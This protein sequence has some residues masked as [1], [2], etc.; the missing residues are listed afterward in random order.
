MT[1]SQYFG[2]RISGGA[3]G[4]FHT[5]ENY[6]ENVLSQEKALL[7]RNI[8]ADLQ[9]ILGFS[10]NVSGE[11][12]ER[13]VSLLKAKI[14][15]P[16]TQS[17]TNDGKVQSHICRTMAE[18]LNHRYGRHVI[19]PNAAP[20]IVC[21]QVSE[22]MS[23]LF[24]GVKSEFL[25]VSTDV[26]RTLDNLGIL[27]RTLESMFDRLYG[28]VQAGTDDRVKLESYNIEHVYRDVL[29]EID[30]QMALLSNMMNLTMNES[31][32]TIADLT[33][34]DKDFYGLI[35]S[36]KNDVGGLDLS[37]KMTYVLNNI[38]NVAVAAQTI[39]RALRAIG[40]T[41]AE[42]KSSHSVPQLLEK[43]HEAF[44]RKNPHPSS[45]D[46][47]K[48][49]AVLQI[50]RSNDYSWD[51][52]TAHINSRAERVKA[53]PR[54]AVK[55]ANRAGHKR[56][57]KKRARGGAE[58]DN[59]LEKRL[60]RQTKA[61][62]VLFRDFEQRLEQQYK[63]I[64]GA[65][66]ILAK[67]LGAQVPL[68]DHLHRFVR[69]MES[70]SSSGVTRENFYLALTGYQ[71]D[72]TSKEER[73]RFLG[74][75]TAVSHALK[76]L[77]GGP[78]GEHF[79]T[80]MSAVDAVIETI[81][82]FKDTYLEPLTSISVRTA[83]GD[84]DMIDDD[85]DEQIAYGGADS[86]SDSNSSDS[87]DLPLSTAIPDAPVSPVASPMAAP[88]APVD[89]ITTPSAPT[90]T[91]GAGD[92]TYVTLDQAIRH[93]MFFFNVAKVK[94]NLSIASKDIKGY[95][96]DYETVLGDAMGDQIINIKKQYES[97]KKTYDGDATDDAKLLTAWIADTPAGSI[98]GIAAP[99][100]TQFRAWRQSIKDNALKFQKEQ[101]NVKIDLIKTVEAI[102]IYLSKF[103]DAIASNPN[104]VKELNQLLKS[105]D[106]IAKW[107]TDRSGNNLV[108]LFESTPSALSG[109]EEVRVDNI[110]QD[111]Q[112]HYYNWVSN[113][114]HN[115]DATKVRLPAN[116]FLGTLPG[117]ADADEEDSVFDEI[118]ERAKKVAMTVRVLDNI[119]ST[120]AK[121]GSQYGQT[122]LNDQ[123]FMPP[124]VMLK[125]LRR[126]MYH[127]SIVMGMQTLTNNSY[128][129]DASVAS[130]V[131]QVG[132]TGAPGPE[133]ITHYKGERIVVGTD[134]FGAHSV[135]PSTLLAATA[136]KT[137]FD[138][139]AADSRE[140]AERWVRSKFCIA[141]SSIYNANG[142][143]LSG[144][145]NGW[146]ETDDLFLMT[147]KSMIAKVFTVI[148]TYDVFN[149]PLDHYSSITNT[150][151]ILG[152]DFSTPEIIPSAVELYIRLPLLAEFYREVFHFEDA[153]NDQIGDTK[154]RRITMVPEFDGVWQNFVRI[155]FEDAKYV[156]EGTYSEAQVKA[157][158]REI[159]TIYTKYKTPEDKTS[160]S[161][162]IAAFIAEINRRYGV[163]KQDEINKYVK[164]KR[165]YDATETYNAEEKLDYDLLDEKNAFG[166]RPAPSDR[167]DYAIA[168]EERKVVSP[169]DTTYI[170]LVRNFR[171]SLDS[172]IKKLLPKS[173]KNHVSFDQTIRTYKTQVEHAKDNAE[174]YRVILKAM[175]GVDHLNTVNHQKALMFHEMVVAPL[176]TLYS[177]WT[178]MDR[179][180]KKVEALD[181]AAI[182]KI[183]DAVTKDGAAVGKDAD[184][185]TYFAAL[186]AKNM[187][188]ER[189][190]HTGYVADANTG[191][192]HVPTWTAGTGADNDI[193]VY[194]GTYGA[195]S[196]LTWS[197]IPLLAKKPKDANT[198]GIR[199]FVV[200]RELIFKDLMNLVFALGSDLGELT[201]VRVQ[202][203]N[204]I[205]EYGKLVE[206]ASALLSNVKKNLELFRGV[207]DDSVIAR[208]ESNRE[209]GSIY[210]LDENLIE[211]IF[212]DSRVNSGRHQY[213]IGLSQANEKLN[214]T[215]KRLSLPWKVT[216]NLTGV[217]TT[218][219]APTG[220][221]RAESS[222]SAVDRALLEYERGLL[223]D[224]YERPMANLLYWS[225]T[226]SYDGAAFRHSLAQP[227]VQNTRVDDWPYAVIPSIDRMG[228]EDDDIK[229]L[230]TIEDTMKNMH[231]EIK[232]AL[233]AGYQPAAGPPPVNQASPFK[234]FGQAAA[235]VNWVDVTDNLGIEFDKTL[236][237]PAIPDDVKAR[238]TALGERY[239]ALFK[240]R[241]RIYQSSIR[242]PMDHRLKWY[243]DPSNVKEG[244]W[245]LNQ[246]HAGD[247]N[248]GSKNQFD[249]GLLVRLNE[250]L[251][252]YLYNGWDATSR[253]MYSG[254]INKFANG[255][256][257]AAVTKGQAI[258]DIDW[259]Q[260]G[261]LHHTGIL[262]LPAQHVS[263]FA[264]LARAMR[265]IMV[266]TRRSGDPEFRIDTMMDVPIH[267]KETMRANLPL[268]DKLFRL[269]IKKAEFLR[270]VTLHVSLV[271][272]SPYSTKYGI[273]RATA[274][275]V[276]NPVMEGL[277]V[278]RWNDITVFFDT[279]N[280]PST[281]SGIES[282]SHD[283]Y[284]PNTALLERNDVMYVPTGVVF[285]NAAPA[286]LSAVDALIAASPALQANIA[287]GAAM[288]A[289]DNTMW[290]RGTDVATAPY[291][292]GTRFNATYGHKAR[293]HRSDHAGCAY[294]SFAIYEDLGL[295]SS[296]K[297][298][299]ELA[300]EIANAASSLAKCASET[301]KELADEPKYLETH[302]GFISDYINMNKV[303]PL[304][305][306]SQLQIAIRP[307]Y[308]S[309]SANPAPNGGEYDYTTESGY[310]RP[311]FMLP[312][313]RSGETPFK[314]AYGSRLVLGRPDVKPSL[315]YMPGMSSL[316]ERYN[317][318]CSAD[319]RIEKSEYESATIAHTL[320]L[321][322]V[323]ELKF[324]R[325]VLDDK[326]G[327]RIYE[328]L[329]IGGPQAAPVG[330]A[331]YDC[332]FNIP[333]AAQPQRVEAAVTYSDKNK[334]YALQNSLDEVI[335]ITESPDQESSMNEIISS[336]HAKDKTIDSRSNARFY[337]IIDMNIVPINVHALT[338]EI[339]LIN[340]INY[341]YTYDRIVQD[342]L[343]PDM[344]VDVDNRGKLISDAYVPTS[345]KGMLTKMLLYPYA[346]VTNNEYYGLIA[347]IATGD[348]GMNLG[349][350]KFISD[351]LW[352]KLLLQELYTQPPADRQRRRPDES[353]PAGDSAQ[354]R[355]L[356]RY[357]ANP[358]A[359]MDIMQSADPA[360]FAATL[361]NAAAL[362]NA[363][364]N[365]AQ[366]SRADASQ[367][368][369]DIIAVHPQPNP[370]D[371]TLSNNTRVIAIVQALS[372][373][374]AS[375]SPPDAAPLAPARITALLTLLPEESLRAILGQYIQAATATTNNVFRA[376]IALLY[377]VMADESI[378]GV[379][380]PEATFEN[381]GQLQFAKKTDE[382]IEL[383]Q[384]EFTNIATRDSAIAVRNDLAQIGR[385]R[386]DTTLVRNLFFLCNAQRVMRMIM[387]DEVQY[388]ES[389]V[390]NASTVL[391]REITDFE[392][393][394]VFDA[395]VFQN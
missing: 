78:S 164:S 180:I 245:F 110:A 136:T 93:L 382:G 56:H 89:A 262:G 220:S 44:E 357:A 283:Y 209:P 16:K 65:V 206:Y 319:Q 12:L 224:S 324:F 22:L 177:V 274:Q 7:I 119:V 73:Q 126:Y 388:L 145:N 228:G 351:Q 290:I 19:D 312:L 131:A 43:I 90:V 118:I 217:N 58:G 260:H 202:Q 350:P 304:M 364:A 86:D 349:R 132:A 285:R 361:A 111:P 60:D 300:D 344:E 223:F 318:V 311:N 84:P 389:P 53:A 95:S 266:N 370:F 336:I 120:F 252:K 153:K 377:W 178:I 235:Q 171:N 54:K 278:P 161:D 216:A 253:K 39:D 154:D 386:F 293:N 335:S 356:Q 255:S 303:Q 190:L 267:M 186:Q 231:K 11:P 367:E 150:R 144:F 51:D 352:N 354:R 66:D 28:A 50:I 163:V 259:Q 139:K 63:Q 197:S 18:V 337:N 100:A 211:R 83:G 87:D 173:V 238:L 343:L 31:T 340:V 323:T 394:E 21:Q 135:V 219:A 237:N 264:S 376:C 251:A 194:R 187:G 359:I 183:I 353:G 148:G 273:N 40:M 265:N 347:R 218:F 229:A 294:M 306:L 205:V 368:I 116:P 355:A 72:A 146:K 62:D 390:V 372:P 104:D 98:P 91:A 15:N 246:L 369:R 24:G 85:D 185:A 192:S 160:V 292:A 133:D 113:L 1:T 225:A 226:S 33:K 284:R 182:E 212:K 346:T 82:K 9:K 330:S 244:S 334:S 250:I 286:L 140:D 387:R 327:G 125:N 200:N 166:R 380:G 333:A 263:V 45:D 207:M 184:F 108:E 287:N 331:L 360:A 325:A 152:G 320:L 142:T 74:Q 310:A 365:G 375:L 329:Y 227:T 129:I 96:K 363:V 101:M 169:W 282:A 174:R 374:L 80:I 269:V 27:R 208:M 307:R 130:T 106:T 103:A 222:L 296:R 275:S 215:F 115:N 198:E 233:P 254:L 247:E 188:Y 230:K 23:T 385:M 313:Y 38:S 35:K 157:L 25:A 272:Q 309:D 167:F 57:G 326:S 280:D 342:A 213:G 10:Q 258:N 210:H 48:F 270:Q 3:I 46:L 298:H 170:T 79:R 261:A 109:N 256:H 373:F 124:G 276:P 248:D 68:D 52:I 151:L 42:F 279:A 20:H 241:E 314:L 257:V 305:L 172:N 75:L 69:T 92:S 159:N 214:S 268:F 366:L 201:T 5:L 138:S 88:E 99:T 191:V 162:V 232:A 338:R 32:R 181:I 147:L 97:F 395:E 107:Y 137:A 34:D 121:L 371:A 291:A 2:G 302:E 315:E 221:D 193:L 243:T 204:L 271:R 316:L 168:G 242:T 143:S 26:R 345:T 322:F 17:I 239:N 321:R 112:S 64:A 41:A 14:P 36:L 117:L 199:R 59:S 297:W 29:G 67:R 384:V 175:Q 236:I 77:C 102:D 393:N 392:S 299:V 71:Q 70:L 127:S 114:L 155:V 381:N 141:F 134:G 391:S 37:R 288:G 179:F 339:P 308:R 249:A 123:T 362:G 332:A 61:R 105:V 128:P 196:D 289:A 195:R 76:P 158:I 295:E 301:Y 189:Y 94:H 81:D 317:G 383:D 149:K 55:R 378:R 13:V 4:G 277:G 234:Y 240:Q 165:R 6:H 49:V 47:A 156:E 379:A 30:R 341:S 8:A 328:P 176:G 122:N 281:A 348:S 358:V 203:N